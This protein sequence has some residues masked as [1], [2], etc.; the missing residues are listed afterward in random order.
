MKIQKLENFNSLNEFFSDRTEKMYSP[1]DI[2]NLYDYIISLPD[3]RQFWQT[4]KEWLIEHQPKTNENYDSEA[5]LLLHERNR[6]L[7]L[8]VERIKLSGDEELKELF[9]DFMEAEN[10]YLKKSLHQS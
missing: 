9:Y 1:K 5:V 3:Y 2:R 7:G 8:I 4:W 6:I 10:K